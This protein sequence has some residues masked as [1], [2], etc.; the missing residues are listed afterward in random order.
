M[1]SNAKQVMI[2]AG[3]LKF[4]PN[5]AASRPAT[6]GPKLVMTR[7]GA[8]AERDRGRPHMGREQF[9][10]VDGVAGKYAE[11]KEP[12]DDQQI[13]VG[14]H[15][16]DGQEQCQAQDQRPNIIKG[17]SRSPPDQVGDEAETRIAE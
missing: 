12:V 10:D 6:N 5:G 2:A 4:S 3:L 8:V 7:A 17:D 16:V 15:A 9:G 11:H 13:R 14:R 1:L